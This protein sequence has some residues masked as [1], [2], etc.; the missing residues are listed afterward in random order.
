MATK[1]GVIGLGGMGGGIASRLL[2]QGH[3]ITVY[4]RTASAADA[5]VAR[6]AQR[7]ATPAE[8]A[9]P[10]GIVITM[11]ANDAALESVATGANGFLDRLG[12]QG[13]HVS[14]STVSV[15][16]VRALAER[17]AARGSGFMAA[18]VFGRPDA[19]AAGKLWILQSGPAAAKARAKPVLEAIGQGVVDIGEA[20]EAAPTGKIA[21]NFLIATAMEALGEAFALLQKSGVDA[22]IWHELMTRTLFAGTIHT[23]YGRFILDRAFSPPGFKLALGAKDV[24]LALAT[25]QDQQ[26][27]MPFASVLHDRFLAAMAQGRSDLDWTAIA[28]GAA[29]DAGL[30]I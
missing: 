6:G 7:A 29:A 18:P 14:M 10:D 19:A 11:V 12:P 27:P 17:H 15:A 3:S 24:G 1:I 30:K 4:N 28:I 23:N 22:R 13:V 25:G 21:G 20:V 16:L 9:A 26:V 2:D 8:A 5:L